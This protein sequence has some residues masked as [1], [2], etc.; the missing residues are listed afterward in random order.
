MY[1]CDKNQAWSILPNAHATDGI[2]QENPKLHSQQSSY[3]NYYELESENV[4]PWQD[5]F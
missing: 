2:A 3:G 5:D 1:S 4:V